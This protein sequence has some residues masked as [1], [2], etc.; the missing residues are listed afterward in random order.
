MKFVFAAGLAVYW[1]L[2]SA[3]LIGWKLSKASPCNFNWIPFLVLQNTHIKIHLS[4]VTFRH[5]CFMNILYKCHS[6]VWQPALPTHLS[7]GANAFFFNPESL[8]H[9]MEIT[10]ISLA[11]LNSRHQ[12]VK[13]CLRIWPFSKNS[14]DDEGAEKVAFKWRGDLER[15]SCVCQTGWWWLEMPPR[16][17][18]VPKPCASSWLCTKSNLGKTQ[19]RQPRD[20]GISKRRWGGRERERSPTWVSRTTCRCHRKGRYADVYMQTVSFWR[21]L[22]TGLLH[23]QISVH[24]V[25]VV[26]K[27]EPCLTGEHNPSWALHVTVCLISP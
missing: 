15:P 13:C 11:T 3:M 26:L 27:Q 7:A 6:C 22:L 8:C 9:T 17:D 21:L 20:G 18:A 10:E 4:C 5:V 14:V 23:V 24:K 12:N 2:I 19:V 1:L 25:M 16:P